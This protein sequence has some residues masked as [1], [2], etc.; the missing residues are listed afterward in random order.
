MI[1][2]KDILLETPETNFSA[3]LIDFN[4]SNVSAGQMIFDYVRSHEK[5]APFTYD[6]LAGYPP[7]PYDKSKGAPKGRLTI[8]YGTTDPEYAYPGNKITDQEAKRLSVAG[9]ND[10]AACIRRWQGRTTEFDAHQRK[11]TLSMF[12]A[13]IDFVYNVGCHSAVNGAVFESIESGDYD[14]AYTRLKT[15]EW[16]HESRRTDTAELF[17]QEGFPSRYI[18][19]ANPQFVANFKTKK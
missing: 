6:D 14:D 13:L 11:I 2:L 10:A 8:G 12:R 1:K 16:G 7:K 15:G 3:E 18:N 5:F 4:E 9:I 17:A 19:T